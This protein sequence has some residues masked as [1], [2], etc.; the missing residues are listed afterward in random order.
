MNIISANTKISAV[1][2]ANPNAIDAIAAINPHFRKLQNPFLRKFLAPRVTIAEA[3]RIGHCELT[4]FFEKLKPLGFIIDYGIM[5]N[6]KN[7]EESPG[8]VHFDVELD[9]R[10]D[11][12]SGKDPFKKIIAAVSDLQTGNVLL[13][14]N[15]FEPVPLI[16]ILTEKKFKVYTRTINP[17]T[18][19]TYIER[20]PES[21]VLAVTKNEPDSSFENTLEAYEG[22]MIE[23][24]V[25]ELP[26]PQPMVRI[27]ETLSRIEEGKALFVHHK[28]VPVFLLPELKERHFEHVLRHVADGVQLIIYRKG[29]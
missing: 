4:D 19:H 14:I 18:I 25:R 13:L 29:K 24:D 16:R 1:L 20:T 10:N 5:E 21:K 2:K 11:I 22:K 27:L 3:A 12:A 8:S 23:I 28:K 15:S 17:D 9:V 6:Q 26:M 7:V